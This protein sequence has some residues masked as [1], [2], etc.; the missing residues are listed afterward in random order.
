MVVWE[1]LIQAIKASEE[2]KDFSEFKHQ[3]T[4]QSKLCDLFHH[5]IQST[6]D[7]VKEEVDKMVTLNKEHIAA[8]AAKLKVSL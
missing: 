4:L 2:M 6:P 5:L 3:S 1:G 7:E 8:F